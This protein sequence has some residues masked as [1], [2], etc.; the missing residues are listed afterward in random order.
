MKRVPLPAAVVLAIGLG[1]LGASGWRAAAR[2]R[3]EGVAASEPERAAVWDTVH[4][5]LKLVAHLHGSGGDPRF[6]ERLPAA[7]EVVGEALE[8]VRFVGHAGRV[9]EPRLIRAEL[10]D[11]RREGAERYEVEAREF[12]VTRS[13]SADGEVLG[14]RSD[15]VIGRYAVRRL[16]GGWKVVAWDVLRRDDVMG[17]GEEP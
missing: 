12:W 5:Y 10:R 3:A 2:A 4:L 11:V 1:V 7:P 13:I 16:P 15:V 17:R 6:A 14:T 8:D 9:E